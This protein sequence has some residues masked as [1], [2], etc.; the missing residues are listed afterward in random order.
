[1][2]NLYDEPPPMV[3]EIRDLVEDFVT[4][5]KRGKL[6]PYRG[7]SLSTTA[8]VEMTELMAT[9]VRIFRTYDER[10]DSTTALMLRANISALEVS[11]QQ[12][13]RLLQMVARTG[14]ALLRSQF[15]TLL[16][17]NITRRVLSILREAAANNKAT[18]AELEEEAKRWLDR[19]SSE[20]DEAEDSDVTSPNASSQRSGSINAAP[21]CGRSRRVLSVRF[22]GSSNAMP[23]VSMLASGT[24]NS[25]FTRPLLRTGSMVAAE[26]P[27]Q[28][29]L[30]RAPSKRQ[31]SA[32]AVAGAAFPVKSVGFFEDALDGIEELK[33]EIEGMVDELCHRAP[34]QLHGSD[35]VI[36]VGCTNTTYRYLMEAARAGQSFKTIILE[37]APA[38]SAPVGRVATA[39]REH[40]LTVQVLP[41]SSA[42]AV[43]N[44]CTKVLVGA[45]SVLAN[46]GMLAPI[47]T[48]M[49]CLAARHFAVPTLVATTTL[50]MSPYYPSDQLCTRLVRI[51]RSGAQE[52]PW[53][54]Y[55]SPESVLPSPHGVSIADGG[56][57]FTVHAPVTEYVPPELITLY[58]T[59]DTEFT[60]SQV[61]RF[62]RAN[63]S[64]ID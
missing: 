62:V 48:H 14:D 60:P 50:K 35:T 33:G 61:H 40:G 10:H 37:G 11:T 18:E 43:M 26:I 28:Q 19:V 17:M 36:T 52:M 25:P 5:L 41:D 23:D 21:P 38:A 1:M 12:V 57:A 49:L 51:A 34:R 44:M 31:S 24:A 16:L 45:E 58:A 6:G 15:A 30:K 13:Q 55:G 63:Y 29:L 56:K 2:L 59:N 39:L 4:N 42:F 64:D 9:I 3:Q 47:G 20:S 22:V 27:G 53:S 46:G 54:T 7:E 32:E 8:A